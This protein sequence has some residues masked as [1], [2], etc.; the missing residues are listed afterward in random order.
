MEDILATKVTIPKLN[1]FA[2]ATS[3]AYFLH[4]EP[5]YFSPPLC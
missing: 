1:L 2:I 5:L 4:K 3:K